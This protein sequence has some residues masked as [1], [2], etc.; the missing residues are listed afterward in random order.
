M[1]EPDDCGSDPG[2]G[3]SDYASVDEV[4]AGLEGLSTPALNKIESQARI[5][6]RGTAMDPGDL[7]HTVVERLLIRDGD[8]G[9]H[10]HRMETLAECIYR[11]MKSIV[12]DHWRRQQIGMT[13]ISAGAAGLQEIASP[14]V[15]LIARQEL[16]A[17]L[18]S[19][20]DSH[21]S[22]AIALALASG[23]T[24]A[25]VRQ[26]FRLSVTGYESALKR[27]RRGILKHTASGGRT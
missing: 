15:Q 20:D 9:R 22:A 2:K 16:R 23:H 10:W 5:L 19:L 7:I 18:A 13:A 26:Q 8:H 24:P 17:V 27:I 14:E 1:T 3:L 25:E 21:E 11:T 12:R 6:V 4:A